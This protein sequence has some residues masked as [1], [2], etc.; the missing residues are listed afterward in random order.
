MSALSWIAWRLQLKGTERGTFSPM[1]LFAWL[2]IGVG[3]AAMGSLLSVM[4]GFE[5]SLRD[6]VLTAYPHLMVQGA[7]GQSAI[8]SPENWTTKLREQPGVKRVIPFVESEMILQGDRRTLGG[9]VWGISLSDFDRFEK[10]LVDGVLPDPKAPTPQVLLGS[11]LA[12]RLGASVGSYLKIISPT[13]RSGLMGM[14]PKA[15]SFQISGVFSTGHYEFDQQYLVLLIEDAQDLLKLK[16]SIS[17]W[18]VWGASYDGASDLAKS[19]QRVVPNGWR[20]QSWEVF[21]SALFHS[22]KLEQYAMFTIL[23]FAIAI[24]VMNIVIT[25]MM[26]VNHKKKKYWHPSGL[27]GIHATDS[28]HLFLARCTLGRGGHGAG[29]NLNGN[30]YRLREILFDF[31]AA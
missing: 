20:V 30:F 4:Y 12:H 8:P 23:S 7:S 19:V 11:E 17:G 14:V 22:L 15:Q 1:T 13:E 3:V 5:S 25:L 10:G 29:G 26:F 28:P 9:V 27:G 2:A 18:H 6:K 21:N 24:A 31:S 16:N